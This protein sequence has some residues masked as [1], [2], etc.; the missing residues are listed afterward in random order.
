MRKK[1]KFIY[2]SRSYKSIL[3]A[4]EYYEAAQK[5]LGDYFLASL[6]DCII[7]IDSNPEIY[8]NIYKTYRQAKVKR[9]PFIIIF[10]LNEDEIIIENVFNT[11]QN[12]IKK[13]K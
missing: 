5:D 3:K 10:R 9:F 6:E 4:F 12:P 1:H 11:Y 13:I 7:S 2:T 8:K